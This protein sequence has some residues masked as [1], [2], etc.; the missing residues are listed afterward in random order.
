[1]QKHKDRY[2]NSLALKFNQWKRQVELVEL[3][4]GVNTLRE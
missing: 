1:V 4:D 3:K 2:R